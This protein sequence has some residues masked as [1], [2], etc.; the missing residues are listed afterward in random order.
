MN[1]LAKSTEALKDYLREV[2][3]LESYRIIAE[4]SIQNLEKERQT[5]LN[6]GSYIATKGKMTWNWSLRKLLI[7][8]AI[9]GIGGWIVGYTFATVCNKMYIL[10]YNLGLFSILDP[11]IR[12]IV[13]TLLFGGPFILPIFLKYREYRTIQQQYNKNLQY[14][15]YIKEQSRRALEIIEIN[16]NNLS[17]AHHHIKQLLNQIYSLDVIYQKYRTLEAC[18]SM[19]EYLEAGRCVLLQGSDGAYN[20]YESEA[21]S[22][23]IIEQLNIVNTK[24]DTLIQ[25]QNQLNWA[26]KNIVVE[27]ADLRNDMQTTF[28]HMA[29]DIKQI[30]GSTAVTAWAT[31]K[32]AYELPAQN[33]AILR[34][35]KG[36]HR[37]TYR[38]THGDIANFF[39]D[40]YVSDVL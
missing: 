30:A 40:D 12:T 19:L 5:W 17:R 29:G 3:K 26:V 8:M 7:L 34:T 24:L 2:V 13:Y 23:K 6:K 4:K 35:L 1:E 9:S 21:N 27:V 31:S 15:A 16:K 10:I 28:Q 20:L 22:K 18:S 32:L 39:V 38:Q 14:Q 33:E 25:Q 11:I 36:I 37:Q